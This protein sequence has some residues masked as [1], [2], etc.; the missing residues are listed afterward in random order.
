MKVLLEMNKIR[1]GCL[2]ELA[3][4]ASDDE[5][6][7]QRERAA[8]ATDFKVW[9]EERQSLLGSLDHLHRILHETDASRTGNSLEQRIFTPSA[10]ATPLS[11]PPTLLDAASPGER[12]MSPAMLSSL[13]VSRCGCVAR[14]SRSNMKTCPCLLAAAKSPL[15]R[16]LY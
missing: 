9:Q 7:L 5:L 6:A 11:P 2:E 3:Q 13:A 4:R 15:Q 12:M 14:G 16:L 1:M 10:S 8:H